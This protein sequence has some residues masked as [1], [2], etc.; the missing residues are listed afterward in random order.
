MM[1]PVSASASPSDDSGKP[2]EASLSV[3]EGLPV[4]YHGTTRKMW[5]SKPE[6]PS[7]LYLTSSLE[8]A[9]HYATETSESEYEANRRTRIHVVKLT[10]Q[11]LATILQTPG[12]ELQ[13][14]WGWVEAQEHDAKR[15]RGTFTDADSTWQNSLAKC[16]G[17][18][19]AGF[20]NGHKALFVEVNMDSTPEAGL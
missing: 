14:D 8:G 10:P 18:V 12:V 5:R 4:L 17:L 20:Q 15:N 11:A 2:Q 3:I 6:S 19:I 16:K 13:P 9:E 1:K 7:C